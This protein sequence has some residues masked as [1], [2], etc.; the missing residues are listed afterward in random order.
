MFATTRPYGGTGHDALPVCL[1]GENSHRLVSSWDMIEIIA[2]EFTSIWPRLMLWSLGSG[3]SGDNKP[4]A[5]E[6]AGIL[7]VL[8][9]VCKRVGWLDLGNQAQRLL[10]N[11]NDA[12]VTTEDL[13]ILLQDLHAALE[14]KFKAVPIGIIEERDYLIFNNAT[15]DLC[16][17]PLHADLSISEEECNQIG[18][19]SCRERV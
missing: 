15:L 19:A 2:S 17:G 11:A 18:R 10:R 4:T 6:L 7:G 14:D 8:V 5:Q 3:L 16:G 13:G 12:T 9:K 1:G